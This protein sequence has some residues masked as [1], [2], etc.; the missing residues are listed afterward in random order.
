MVGPSEVNG[1][2]LIL[3][4]LCSWSGL[5]ELTHSETNE[6]AGSFTTVSG[7]AKSED[8]SESTA[9]RSSSSDT[10]GKGADIMKFIPEPHGGSTSDG[11]N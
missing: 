4:W 5:C 7:I 10:W 8:G 1:H 3:T 9:I 2:A 6:V 11:R